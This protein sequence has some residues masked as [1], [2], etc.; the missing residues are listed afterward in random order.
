MIRLAALFLLAT[1]LI[2]C[3]QNAPLSAEATALA[4]A[5]EQEAGDVKMCGAPIAFP[6]GSVAEEV[7]TRSGGHLA[8]TVPDGYRMAQVDGAWQAMRSASSAGGTTQRVPPGPTYTVDCNCQDSGELGGS[9]GVCE[10]Q[11]HF[12][13]STASCRT[14]GCTDCEMTVTQTGG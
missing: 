7:T 2:A 14:V 9:T 11:F 4:K 13:T 12:P 3:D 1:T 8:I 10:E 5:P 6:V